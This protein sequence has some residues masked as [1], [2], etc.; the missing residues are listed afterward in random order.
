MVPLTHLH[1]HPIT[2]IQ[3]DRYTILM[4]LELMNTFNLILGNWVALEQLW[5]WKEGGTYLLF[6]MEIAGVDCVLTSPV[7]P[8]PQPAPSS[9]PVLPGVSAR[10]KIVAIS[11]EELVGEEVHELRSSKGESACLA[12]LLHPALGKLMSC[13]P[14]VSLC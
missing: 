8:P 14:P 10:G 9:L 3:V 11:V 5:S 7:L 13:A 4:I 1:K 2:N 6:P 12:F